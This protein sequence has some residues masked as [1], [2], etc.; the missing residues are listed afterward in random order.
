MWAGSDASHN[1]RRHAGV[2]EQSAQRHGR[3][4]EARVTE[5]VR[6]CCVCK[7]LVTH[8]WQLVT[9]C[10][11][12]S[13]RNHSRDLGHLRPVCSCFRLLAAAAHFRRATQ[14]AVP[15]PPVLEGFVRAKTYCTLRPPAGCAGKSI[16]CPTRHCDFGLTVFR[17]LSE[18]ETLL[19]PTGERCA[20]EP[21]NGVRE[22]ESRRREPS[23]RAHL[24][25]NGRSACSKSEDVA[26][27]V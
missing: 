21:G 25:N 17:A 16:R 6:R 22:G 14:L 12:P 15:R 8:H 7:V 24:A 13:P 2:T 9:I 3:T 4:G 11:A 18:N 1:I 19:Q 10:L 23:A 5:P 27:A 20:T 26:A